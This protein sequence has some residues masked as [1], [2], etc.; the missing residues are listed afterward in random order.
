M[1]FFKARK[2]PFQR[3][4]T[5][6]TNTP[7]RSA[8][9]RTSERLAAAILLQGSGRT[10][11]AAVRWRE[12]R[13]IMSGRI[14]APQHPASGGDDRAR[15]DTPQHN[16]GYCKPPV[17]LRLLYIGTLLANIFIPVRQ[18]STFPSVVPL[19]LG[20]GDI[21]RPAPPPTR[22]LSTNQPPGPPCDRTAHSFPLS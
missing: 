22:S 10:Q 7:L 9:S 21:L 2:P 12:R 6:R 5:G 14:S 15:K 17:V 13:S 19:S 3:A 16:S 11:S 4:G 18:P 1:I 20:P 8:V